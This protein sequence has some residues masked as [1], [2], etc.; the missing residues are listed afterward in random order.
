MGA[1]HLVGGAGRRIGRGARDLDPAHR[2]DGAAFTLLGLAVV[3]AAR[4][5]WGLSGTAGTVIHQVVAGTF[6]LVGVAVP[7]LLLA[8]AVRLMRHP[9]KV[10]ANGRM[11]IG[12]STLVLTA[13]GMAHLAN[14]GP[15]LDA[16]VD[17]GP[18]VRIPGVGFSFSGTRPQGGLFDV[19]AYEL[20]F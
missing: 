6:G 9:D 5:W 19:G 16:G 12:M 18:Y 14:G 20:E 3:V 1:A 15:N 13:C 10:E 11:G 4:E 2:R 8:V 17:P 7:L